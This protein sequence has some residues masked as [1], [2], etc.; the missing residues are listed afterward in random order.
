MIELFCVLWELELVFANDSESLIGTVSST[1]KKHDKIYVIFSY[2][3]WIKKMGIE[4]MGKVR[5]AGTWKGGQGSLGTQS[6]SWYLRKYKNCSQGKMSNAGPSK[7][8]F[9]GTLL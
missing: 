3:K 7:R 4:K 6:Q 1:M 5:S 2:L 8:F 9:Q